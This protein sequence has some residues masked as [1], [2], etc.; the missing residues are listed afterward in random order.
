MK[1]IFFYPGNMQ[2]FQS[3]HSKEGVPQPP[4]L[5]VGSRAHTICTKGSTENKDCTKRDCTFL[6]L[7]T[8]EKVTGGLQDMHNWV[9]ETP[10]VQW[11]NERMF[12]YA[13]KAGDAGEPGKE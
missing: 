10:G 6:H 2:Q 12:F 1:G 11:R 8:L 4:K 13:E 3:K 7:A 5:T 9:V